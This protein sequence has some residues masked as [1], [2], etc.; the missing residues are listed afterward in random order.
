MLVEIVENKTCV[1]VYNPNTH[2]YTFIKGELFGYVDLQSCGVKYD[3]YDQ[4]F[5]LKPPTVMV[6][7]PIFAGEQDKTKALQTH[8]RCVCEPWKAHLPKEG[9]D[10]W[11]WLDKND[12]KRQKTDVEILRDQVKLP[13]HLN[14]QTVAKLFADMTEHIEAFSLRNEVRTCPFYEVHLSLT[15]DTPFFIRPYD[16]KQELVAVMDKKVDRF[17]KRGIVVQGHT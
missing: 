9:E 17:V 12:P 15:D 2:P 4:V 14:E 13:T 1:Q 11:P 16:L 6:M 10:Q 8:L 7:Q 5:K 3:V